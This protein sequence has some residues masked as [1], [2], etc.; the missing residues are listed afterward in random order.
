[1]TDLAKA[2]QLREAGHLEE[3]RSVLLKLI[4]LEPINPLVWFQCAWVHDALG[5]ESE[6]V[7]YYTK[8]LELGLLGEERQGAYLGLGSTYRA[9]GLYDE[10][11]LLFEQAIQE[12]PDQREF[13]IF[14]AMVLYNLKDYSKA[15]E[16]VL[17]QLLETSNDTGIQSYSRAISFYSDKLDQTWK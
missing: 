4:T 13:R 11:K 3:A 6:A 16:I 12:Y 9:L 2:I 8:A 10:S 7:P 15:M 1:M 14:Y 17:Q 5:S